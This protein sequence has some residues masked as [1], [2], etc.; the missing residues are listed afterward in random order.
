MSA[1]ARQLGSS[2]PTLAFGVVAAAAGALILWLG[3]GGWFFHD[4][5]DFL[6]HRSLA[7]PVSLFVPHNEHAVVLPAVA[8]RAVADLAGAESYL[9]FLALLVAAHIATAAGLFAILRAQSVSL[10][11]GAA[12]LF[13]FFGSGAD[14]LFW[15]FQITFIGST[16]FGVWGLWAALRDRW[17]LAS[18]LLVGSVFSSLVG[19]PFLIAVAVLAW[20]RRRRELAWL[21][22][23]ILLLAG[24][25]WTFARGWV[26][27]PDW[28]ADA[29]G[30]PLNLESWAG[31]PVFLFEAAA[32]TIA[33]VTGQGLAFAL[34]YLIVGTGAILVAISRGWRPS[35]LQVAALLGLVS[36]AV[37]AGVVRAGA[38]HRFESRFVYVTAL[39][40]LLMLPRVRMTPIRWGLAGLVLVIALTANVVALQTA[41]VRWDMRASEVLACEL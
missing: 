14:N 28:A 38:E 30:S 10:A 17:R 5:C 13:I 2:S 24:W 31:V 20:F 34:A 29:Y 41:A 18:I 9:P 4:D 22:L 15:A 21:L 7:E 16:A 39:F 32:W 8:Y 6:H 3:R 12:G 40:A 25:W 19:L 11:L 36:F 23:P 33:D 26:R 1:S 35:P 27:P 37:M